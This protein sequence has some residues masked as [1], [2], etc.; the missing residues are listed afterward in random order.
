M[1]NLVGKFKVQYS[2]LFDEGRVRSKVELTKDTLNV[3]FKTVTVVLERV[4]ALAN[5]LEEKCARA[6]GTIMSESTKAILVKYSDEL[7]LA[8]DT[9]LSE[10]TKMAQ[11][12]DEVQSVRGLQLF[13]VE[14]EVFVERMLEG[15]SLGLEVHEE[16]KKNMGIW[17]KDN[18]PKVSYGSETGLGPPGP[19]SFNIEVHGMQ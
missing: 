9:V 13:D 7:K 8:K 16:L 15:W 1:S 4:D 17:Y 12:W 10:R 3:V 18:F 5:E 14:D 11:K 6:R 19:A 2:D